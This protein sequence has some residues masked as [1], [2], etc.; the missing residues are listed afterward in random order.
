MDPSLAA[1][2][3]FTIAALALSPMLRT[4]R[5]EAIKD[6]ITIGLCA[7]AGY[8]AQGMSLESADA[9]TAAFLC[10]LAVIVCPLMDAFAGV[11]VQSSAWAAACL[12]VGGA[13]VLEL[14]GLSSPGVGDLLALIQPLAFGAGFWRMERAMRSNPD[15]GGPLTALQLLVV[16]VTACTWSIL[17]DGSGSPMGELPAMGSLIA[18]LADTNVKIALAWTGLVTTA[19]TVFLETTALGRLPSAEVTVLFSTEPLWGT[20]FAAAMLGE[21]IGLNTVAGGGLIMAAVAMRTLGGGDE[22]GGGSFMTNLQD[23]VWVATKGFSSAVCRL[24]P[25]TAAVVGANS[26][27]AAEAAEDIVEIVQ[28]VDSVL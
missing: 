17:S 4:L 26:A 21:H 24:G 10:S 18:A 2:M 19:M 1:A 28:K 20:A 6:G 14:G 9:S 5:P 27:S 12:A 16:A 11:K 22:G 25:S 13:A 3:R 15:Q 8:I 23:K 7:S